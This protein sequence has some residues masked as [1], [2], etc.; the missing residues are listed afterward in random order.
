MSSASLVEKRSL[1][2]S[3]SRNI[4]TSS[5]SIT[6]APPTTSE[7]KLHDS[8]RQL[9]NK[10]MRSKQR[11]SLPD[12]GMRKGNRSAR[13]SNFELSSSANDFDK[14]SNDDRQ[15]AAKVA[16]KSKPAATNVSKIEK[17]QPDDK[18]M[19]LLEVDS[20]KH[21]NYKYVNNLAAFVRVPYSHELCVLVDR[22]QAEMEYMELKKRVE[23]L[24]MLIEQERRNPTSEYDE[25]INKQKY[26]NE[27][28]RA[29][30]GYINPKNC[31]TF[32]VKL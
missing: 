3:Q 21:E 11:E 16:S 14:A 1:R 27:T 23:E 4:G 29:Q 24:Q 19:E 26:F 15:S 32:L 25:S 30:V 31:D 8:D 2:K 7:S 22:K 28:L 12:I 5:T 18:V 6:S 10:S 20:L 9:K 13:A 17:K